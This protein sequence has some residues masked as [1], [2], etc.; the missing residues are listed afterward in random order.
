MLRIFSRKLLAPIAVTAATFDQHVLGSDLAVMLV[1]HSRDSATSQ[2]YLNLADSVSDT[3]NEPQ[4]K[5]RWLKYCTIDADQQPALAAAFDVQRTRLPV[6]Y[7]VYGGTIIDRLTGSPTKEKLRECLHKFRV[8]YTNIKHGKLDGELQSET[9]VIVAAPRANL[10]SDS[11]V[12]EM[13]TYLYNLPM[14][15]STRWREI[16]HQALTKAISEYSTLK[17]KLR[18]DTRQVSHEEIVETLYSQTVVQQL[19]ILLCLEIHQL[20]VMGEIETAVKRLEEFRKNDQH[21]LG[22]CGVHAEPRERYGRAMLEVVIA[23][24]PPE[25]SFAAL[26]HDTFLTEKKYA[27]VSEDILQMLKAARADKEKKEKCRQALIGIITYL[28]PQHPISTNVRQ[29]MNA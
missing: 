22:V 25:S 9:E 19:A 18:L 23:K 17:K 28:G 29:R 21:I 14:K 20:C 10:T 2:D 12:E 24:E 11:T 8:H 27:G 3:M 16:H 26:L 13:V 7:F 5:P 15:E 4:P 6:T 1:Y